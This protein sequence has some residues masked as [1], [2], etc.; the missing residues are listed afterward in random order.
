MNQQILIRLYSSAG[1]TQQQPTGEGF[2]GMD[3]EDYRLTPFSHVFGLTRNLSSYLPLISGLGYSQPTYFSYPYPTDLSHF[4]TFRLT[5]CRASPN[6]QI[7]CFSQTAL[8]LPTEVLSTKR[9]KSSHLKN[10]QPKLQR[11]PY[12][13]KPLADLQTSVLLFSHSAYLPTSLALTYNST[14]VHSP[15]ATHT[16]WHILSLIMPPPY[17]NLILFFFGRDPDD[18]GETGRSNPIYRKRQIYYRSPG[19]P[20]TH[21]WNQKAHCDRSD[22]S[23]AFERKS[24]TL[25]PKS[26]SQ[27]S[28]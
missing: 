15:R 25:V 7:W 26:K 28:N 9:A 12:L 24:F 5:A 27:Y 16:L 11:R 10:S 2:P 20:E 6:F 3:G 23:A 18:E 1:S 13:T 8:S 21:G 4:S 14:N 19:S 22:I 17:K